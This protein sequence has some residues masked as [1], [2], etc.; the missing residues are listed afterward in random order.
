MVKQRVATADV[1]AEVACL[2]ARGIEGMRVTNV[3]DVSSRVCL[4]E[5]NFRF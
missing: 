4:D 5:L 3:Y 2:K 1:A